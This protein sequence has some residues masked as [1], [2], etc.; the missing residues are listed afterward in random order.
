MH[1]LSHTRSHTRRAIKPRRGKL[2]RNIG[3]DWHLNRLALSLRTSCRM[4]TG[5]AQKAASVV[6]QWREKA[7][8]Y[9]YERTRARARPRECAYNTGAVIV[10][11]GVSSCMQMPYWTG[12]SSGRISNGPSVGRLIDNRRARACASGRANKFRP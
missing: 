2:N 5:Q 11:H 12:Q 1:A 7:F 6:H 9:L 3:S 10:G 4:R 8:P